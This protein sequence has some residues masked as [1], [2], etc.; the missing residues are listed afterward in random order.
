MRQM[1]RNKSKKKVEKNSRQLR[2]DEF[3]NVKNVK[4]QFLYTK[5]GYVMTY[6]RVLPYNLDLL[7]REEKGAKTNRQA[8][9]FDSDRRDFAYM[10]FFRELDLDSYKNNL[11]EKHRATDFIGNRHILEEMMMEATD[12]S[13]NGENFEHQHYIK[14]WKKI[15]GDLRD[16]EQEAKMRAEEFRQRYAEVGITVYQI[17]DADILKMCN[18]YGNTIQAPYDSV[19]DN[20]IYENMLKILG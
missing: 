7:P 9:S 4:G 11:K 1:S 13:V 17:K 2:A 5:D 18:L 3:T 12:L 20:M 15:E 16:A 10:S 19:S 6:L 8:A 14:I